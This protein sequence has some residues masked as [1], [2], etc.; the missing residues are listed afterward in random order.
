MLQER[1]LRKV[2]FDQADL[3]LKPANML[4][5]HALFVKN[6]HFPLLQ[7][8]TQKQTEN[9]R[10][11]GSI[12]T[13]RTH[14]SEQEAGEETRPNERDSVFFVFFMLPFLLATKIEKIPPK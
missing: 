8:K 9:L 10:L 12:V 11:K 3:L 7:N 14:K 2:Q 6:E 13:H 4:L 1:E 5:N